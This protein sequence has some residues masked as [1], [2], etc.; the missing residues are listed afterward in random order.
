MGPVLWSGDHYRGAYTLH[1]TRYVWALHVDGQSN[2]H[3]HRDSVTWCRADVWVCASTA[4]CLCSALTYGRRP[5]DSSH[6]LS[7]QDGGG[8]RSRRHTDCPHHALCAGPSQCVLYTQPLPPRLS[9]SLPSLPPSL[10]PTSTG[11]VSIEADNF[12]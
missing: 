6:T 11:A 9:L 1:P 2:G 8:R 5:S 10:T 3:T 7:A 4:A 12:C